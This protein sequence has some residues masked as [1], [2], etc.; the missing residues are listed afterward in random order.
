MVIE[1]EEE[2][3]D[4]RRRKEIKLIWRNEPKQAARGS[5]EGAGV[6]GAGLAGERVHFACCNMLQ[7]LQSMTSGAEIKGGGRRRAEV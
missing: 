3:G 2:E 4:E 1:E 6:E 5:V 7:R